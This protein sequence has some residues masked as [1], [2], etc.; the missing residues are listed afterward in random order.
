LSFCIGSLIL[1][2]VELSFFKF[3]NTFLFTSFAIPSFIGFLGFF[4]DPKSRTSTNSSSRPSSSFDGF[5]GFLSW[6]IFSFLIEFDL[7][8][9][10]GEFPNE[11]INASLDCFLD[12][13]LFSLA[14]SCASRRFSNA[15]FLCSSSRFLI[16]SCYLFLL[17]SS[18][19]DNLVA[20][21]CC[22]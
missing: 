12:S 22:L 17:E 14:F 5:L 9:S 6:L 20:F 18:C 4:L 16:T 13:S 1:D 8:V 2:G 7:R 15:A 19:G 21:C 10:C 11:L 3:S